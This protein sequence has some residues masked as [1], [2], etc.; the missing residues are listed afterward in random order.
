MIQSEHD[1]KQ[2]RA[3]TLSNGLRVLL[4]ENNA[5]V[6][7][8]AA[9]AVN[10][11][12][13]ND[14][15]H[16]EGIAHFLEHMLFLGTEKYPNGS[17][18]QQ[19]ISQYNGHN[20]AWTGTEHTCFFFDIHHQFF[21]EALA[22][23]SDFFISPLLSQDFIE[24]ERQNIDAE[25]KLKLKDEIRRLYD[26]HKETINPEHPF[27]QF[28]VGN[29]QT[30]ADESN[31]GE[32]HCIQHELRAF[33]TNHY[34]AQYMTL[35]LEGPQ[36]LDELSALAEQYFSSIKETSK[37]IS[38]LEKPLYLDEHQRI[39]INICPVKNDKQLI[40]SF[41]M[42]SIDQFYQDK[43][44]S[45]IAYL[46]GYE[47]DGS[48]LSYLKAKQWALRL[49]AGSGIN[50]S[51]FKDFN[52]N[53]AL[54]ELG[55]QYINEIVS[56]VFE[57]IGL[58]K[59]KPIEQHYFNEKQVMNLLA[60]NVQEVLKPIDS[61]SQYVIN[62]QHYPE[63][64]YLF[65]DYIM[66]SLKKES[67]DYLL[68]F[69]SVDNMRLLHISQSNNFDKMSK[70]Y[71]VPYRTTKI[72][73]KQLNVWQQASL[74]TST[75][76]AL[77]LPTKNNYIVKNPVIVPR[78]ESTV[79]PEII[80]KESGF[81]AWFKQD[82]IFNIPKGF[83][84]I[85]IDCPNAL[86]S[87]VNMAMLKLFI[88]IY[89]DNVSE[90]NYDAELAGIHYHL[91][92]HQAGMALQL[93]GISEKQP[94]LLSKL[95]DSLLK[96]NI[97]KDKFSLIK[98]QLLNYWKNAEKSKS[99]S[100]LFNTLSSALQPQKL[101][102]PALH[103]A[104]KD[105]SFENFISFTKTLF[106][107]VHLE[108][109]IHG[110]WQRAQASEML[111]QIKH[112]FNGQYHQDYYVNVEVLDTH[113]TGEHILPMVLPDHDYASV[114]YFPMQHKDIQTIS[115]CMILSQI[116]SPHF[117]QEMRTEKQF[118]YLVGVG[119]V[120]ISFYPG[121][122]LYIQSP[123]TQPQI[124]VKAITSFVNNSISLIDQ[125]NDNDWLQLKHGLCGQLAEHDSTLQ[126]QSQRFW[127]AIGN[128]DYLFNRKSQLI[129]SIEG[130]TL[131][132]VKAFISKVFKGE[133]VDKI[134]LTSFKN[135]HELKVENTIT[136]TNTLNNNIQLKY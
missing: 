93:S 65:G 106:S 32:K 75:N 131:N 5:S 71:E 38:K 49:T 63:Q 48:I 66:N 47:G 133:T 52:I 109:F 34:C 46:L 9:L 87:K 80:H 70:W 1:P 79:L 50:G 43:P 44:E 28:S 134:I 51:N 126:I 6:K 10:A 16:R 54:T 86:E 116:L 105:V 78:D 123:N 108:V 94:L 22:R 72:T 104:L 99:I 21:D 125:F 29:N 130:L 18:Y 83:I 127:G 84:Y 40:I 11:G 132:Q 57:Y 114:V 31:D 53:L 15:K 115:I 45:L 37:D 92:P 122:A 89:S 98:S 19:F 81:I 101:S 136:S 62:M 4:I 60:F 12:H 124:L 23:F 2:Y 36:S 41:A 27:S 55:E 117:F 33:F 110:N 128:Q 76:K 129:E 58:L 120:P 111:K 17:E 68:S 113:G 13:F 82:Q 25:F 8:A 7:S 26:V 96:Q 20:N 100:Q 69:L 3:I 73:S 35:A 56:I 103:D 61:V 88:E 112:T 121:I 39:R 85:N 90:D 64:H 91:Y 135:K 67:V 77:F 42:P 118:G 97:Q 102:M 119:Y 30:L 59:N 24:K 74:L 95:L 107:K 14:P